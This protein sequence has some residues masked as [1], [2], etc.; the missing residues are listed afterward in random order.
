MK[1]RFSQA[2]FWPM[3]FG[4][5]NGFVRNLQSWRVGDSVL[6]PIDNNPT[7]GIVQED[8][9][10]GWYSVL[11]SDTNATIKCRGRQLVATTNSTI[12]DPTSPIN[13]GSGE[14]KSTLI[15]TGYHEIHDLDAALREAW[16]G[17]KGLGSDSRLEQ[18]AHHA[19]YEKWVGT[20][21][22]A[23]IT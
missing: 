16:S 15:D 12:G 10:R 7:P 21:F 1:T 3:L 23:R 20:C 5:S 13:D 22:L 4:L 2:V 9:G 17:D 14:C 19:S 18:I 6:Y 11:L 8:R